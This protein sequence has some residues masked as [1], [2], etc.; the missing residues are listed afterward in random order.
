MAGGC[1]SRG[2]RAG[3]EL[4]LHRVFYGWWILGAGFVA[5]ALLS[6]TTSYGTA[7]FLVPLT[8][9]FGWSRTNIATALALARLE[10]GISGPIEGLLVD[11]WGPRRVMLI[12]IPLCTAGYLLWSQIT[13]LSE[14]TG[15]NVL[16]VFYFVYVAMVGLGA[17]LGSSTAVSTAIVNWFVRRRGFALGIMNS[18][19]GLG[20]AIWVPL[21]GFFI[22]EHGWRWAVVVQGFG[23]LAIGIPAALVM[24]HRPEDYGLRPDGDPPPTVLPAKSDGAQAPSPAPVAQHVEDRPDYTI[25]QAI[26]TSAFWC[27]AFAF[28]FRVMVTNAVQVHLAALLQ[29]LGMSPL[30][31]AGAL[32]LLSALSIVGRLGMAWL[33]DLFEARRVYMAALVLMILGM[34]VLAVADQPWYVVPFLALYSPAYGGLA[35][36][37]GALRADFF[38]R[39]A[40]GAISGVMGPITTLGTMI[41]PLFAGYVFDTTGTYKQALLTFAVCGL[42]SLGL[43]ALAKRPSGAS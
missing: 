6:A 12:G 22:Q 26:A 3:A 19:H 27:L 31:A 39:R 23:I 43:M 4:R 34:L 10:S 18:G 38:G 17:G 24:R 29:D 1:V 16:L 2:G 40:F 9:E 36:L 13:S 32:G 21:L 20:A 5:N 28:A 35:A 8:M 30:S 33:G 14:L 7:L 37:P 15:I 42:I 11:R 41:G 25:R